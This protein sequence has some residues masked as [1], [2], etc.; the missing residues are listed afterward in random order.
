MKRWYKPWTWFTKKDESDDVADRVIEIIG[1]PAED[2]MYIFSKL[3]GNRVKAVK[4]HQECTGS[5]LA[6]SIDFVYGIRKQMIREGLLEHETIG[7]LIRERIE[8]GC[9]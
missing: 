4:R 5:S 8:T 2:S 7:D 1:L 9:K 3:N 6:E